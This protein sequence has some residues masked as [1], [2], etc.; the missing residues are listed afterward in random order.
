MI[1]R[2]SPMDLLIGDYAVWGPSGEKVR[3]LDIETDPYGFIAKVQNIATHNKFYT[4]LAHL[5]KVPGSDSSLWKVLH[6]E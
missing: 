1:Y 4:P 6:D 5:E 3:I 2:E